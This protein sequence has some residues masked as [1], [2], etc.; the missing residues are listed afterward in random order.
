VKTDLNGPADTRMMAIVHTALRRDLDRLRIELTTEPYP[1][2]AQKAAL[3]DH[4]DWMM[5]FLHEH[6]S[7]EDAG[8]Y[9]MVRSRGDGATELLDD[10]DADHRRIDPAMAALRAAAAEWRTGG[11]EQRRTLVEALAEL[12]AV[13]RPHLDRE[14]V[15]AMPLVSRTL[16]QREWH[17]WDQT[18]NVKSK[19]F[20]ELGNSGHWMLDGLD[21]QRR[22]IVL[23]EVPL[24][25]RYVLLW[26][27][28][29]RYRHRSAA[30]WSR[31]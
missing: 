5:D 21:E 24:V 31:A 30:R 16:T 23:H 8:L 3:A 12:D 1:A 13:L 4:V 25:P 27:F 6:H 17:T 26:G 2:G 18:Y 20:S 19:S 11:D 9:P 7:G 29:P 22:Q 14:E 28:G 10:M 15:E